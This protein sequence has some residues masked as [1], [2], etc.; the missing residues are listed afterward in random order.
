MP[1]ARS[2]VVFNVLLL[3]SVAACLQSTQ[4]M[5]APLVHWV[6]VLPLSLLNPAI[7]PVHGPRPGL[8]HMSA[9]EPEICAYRLGKG[10]SEVIGIDQ[11]QV[12]LRFY[13]GDLLFTLARTDALLV[14]S[15]VGDEFRTLARARV[16]GHCSATDFRLLTDTAHTHK[17]DVASVW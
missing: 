12:T 2:L 15:Q 13:P 11:D 8:S 9:L 3:A 10:I 16:S 17:D 1:L 4:A 6:A 14:N 7:T 5:A